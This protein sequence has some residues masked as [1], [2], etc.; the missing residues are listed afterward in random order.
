M[1]SCLV[2]N[3]AF[4]IGLLHVRLAALERGDDGRRVLRRDFDVKRVLRVGLDER[5]FAAK[6]HA[7]DAAHFDFVLQAG[8]G[9]G[10]VQLL[11]DALGVG[12]H[13]AGGH[14]AA[15]SDFFARGQFLFFDCDEVV[16]NHFATHFLMCSSVDSGV[17]RGVT[18]PS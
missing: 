13:A 17:W 16:E 11:L 1:E 5:A 6:F 4:G 14:A 18:V 12:R 10:F 15:Q 9:H 8:F 7:A 3:A 2:K